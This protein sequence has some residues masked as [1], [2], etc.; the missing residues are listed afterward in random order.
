MGDICGINRGFGAEN[1]AQLSECLLSFQEAMDSVHIPHKTDVGVHACNP[2]TSGERG[3]WIRN[4]RPALKIGC[5]PW[6]Y[7]NLSKKQ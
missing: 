2:S 6:I 1:S 5:Q 4:S 3:K 7:E